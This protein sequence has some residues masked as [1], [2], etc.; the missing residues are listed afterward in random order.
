MEFRRSMN[1]ASHSIFDY[2]VVVHI[3]IIADLDAKMMTIEFVVM[4]LVL[5]YMPDLP[6]TRKSC[7]RYQFR[8]SCL[9]RR[10]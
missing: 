1:M 7:F 6:A 3:A 9:V 5:H 2:D 10:M 8:L 4:C